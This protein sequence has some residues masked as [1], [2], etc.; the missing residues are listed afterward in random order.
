M[1][2]DEEDEAEVEIKFICSRN[3]KIG[4]HTRT[5]GSRYKF[6]VKLIVRNIVCPSPLILYQMPVSKPFLIGLYIYIVQFPL[7]FWASLLPTVLCVLSSEKEEKR[8]AFVATSSVSHDFVGSEKAIKS[9]Q[10]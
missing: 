2:L 3:Y 4:L 1:C 9:V 10:K 5:H 6:L 7:D 8:N